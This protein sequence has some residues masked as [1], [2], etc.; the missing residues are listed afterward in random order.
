MYMKRGVVEN[1]LDVFYAMEEKGISTWNPLILWLAMNC[2]EEKS[3]TMFA[4]IERKKKP[5]HF[6]NEII[7]EFLGHVGTW[8]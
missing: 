7:W 3:L 1:A 4:D 8:A 2:L 5:R 6:P